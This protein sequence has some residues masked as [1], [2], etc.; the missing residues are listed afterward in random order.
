ME[1]V[2]PLELILSTREDM[3]A[4][5]KRI[6][7]AAREQGIVLR[8]IGGLAVRFHCKT[9]DF[10]E[11]DH[12]DIDMVGHRRDTER[13]ARLLA[14][15]G[16]GEVVHVRQA[17]EGRQLQFS[18]ECRH[19]EEWAH[20]QPHDNDH[21][22]IFLDNFKMDHAIDLTDR[23][24]LDHYTITVT[25][26]LLTKLQIA[27][28]TEKDERDIFTL[29]QDLELGSGDDPEAIDVQHIAQLCARD[30]GLFHDVRLNLAHLSAR[31]EAYSLELDERGRIRAKL[32]RLEEA[33]DGHPKSGG[34]RLRGKIGERLPWHETV[35][36]Q[37]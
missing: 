27:K 18:R 32:K 23:F 37:D 17:T 16:Y 5:A 25:D 2:A 20:Y 7:D 1:T 13:I 35:E 24:G 12:G 30:W 26:V 8:L 3:I 14:V 36:E 11:R 9:L 15:L 6:I 28:L 33:I 19:K 10:C 31:L 34:W 29:L 22:D 21:V 4:E